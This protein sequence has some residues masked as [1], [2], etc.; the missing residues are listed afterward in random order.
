MRP[1][2]PRCSMIVLV[3]IVSR[4]STMSVVAMCD[5]DRAYLRGKGVV[6]EAKERVSVCVRERQKQKQKQTRTNCASLA[7]QRSWTT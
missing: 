3:M 4:F 6:V 5:G 7:A 2:K 1:K